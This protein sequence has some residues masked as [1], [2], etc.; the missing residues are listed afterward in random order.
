M[1]KFKRVALIVM[2]IVVGSTIGCTTAKIGVVDP[3]R[4]FQESIPGKAGMEHLKSIEETMQT[5][6]EQAQGM[7]DTSSNN[8]RM[9]DRF[10]KIF[11][12]YQQIINREQQKVIEFFNNL[13]Q[14]T[15][16]D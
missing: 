14:K 13:I 3:I 9:Q 16:D 8:Q 12:E 10:Q 15:L 7:L 2:C 5:Q 1:G 6:I 4:L 11:M